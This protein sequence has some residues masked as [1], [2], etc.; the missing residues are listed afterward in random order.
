M[1]DEVIRKRIIYKSERRGCREMDIILSTFCNDHIN[2]FD[3]ADL[4]LMEEILECDDLVLYDY[5]IGRS[6]LPGF[7]ENK[8]IDS[9]KLFA[10]K[11]LPKY[12][13]DA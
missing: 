8:I 9:L 1:S 6:P 3:S 4:V 7:H 13:S 11:M 2:D 10:E 12:K 5:L